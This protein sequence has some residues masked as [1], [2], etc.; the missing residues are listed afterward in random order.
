LCPAC[1]VA[2]TASSLRTHF[3]FYC[4]PLRRNASLLFLSTAAGRSLQERQAFDNILA[5]P[6]RFEA[7]PEK[8]YNDTPPD[9]ILASLDAAAKSATLVQTV[10]SPGGTTNICASSERSQDQ[11]STTCAV[12]HHGALKASSAQ[13]SAPEILLQCDVGC[14]ADLGAGSG[15]HN[16]EHRGSLHEPAAR[17]PQENFAERSER[18]TSLREY[19]AERDR[20]PVESA[21]WGKGGGGGGESPG[22]G[23][24][25]TDDSLA[26][27]A[28]QAS[29]PPWEPFAVRRARG[30]R[31]G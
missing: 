4:S 31:G 2:S 20:A 6:N 8:D 14:Q 7:P 3:L 27:T 23:R 11:Q 24:T 13:H 15:E 12:Q 16:S 9:T 5:S 18:L 26:E 21:G 28:L 29:P 30:G 25:M 10:H 1:K 19:V 22:A 17:A